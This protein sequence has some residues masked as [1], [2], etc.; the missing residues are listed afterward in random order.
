[1]RELLEFKESGIYCSAGDFYIDPWKPV[2]RA[3]LTHAHADHASAGCIHYLAHHHSVPALR[4]RLGEVISAQGV[5]YSQALDLN[6]VKVSLHPAGHIP[7]SAQVRVEYKGQ[8]WVVSGDYKLSDDGLSIPFEPVK[9]HVFVTESTFGL[10]VYTWKRQQEVFNEINQWWSGNREQGKASVIMGYT[11]GK[12]QRILQHVDHSIGKVYTHGAVENMNAVLRSAGIPLLPSVKVFSEAPKDRFRT[13][14]I[15]APPWAKGSTWLSRF[16]PYSL[17][18]ASGWMRLR[19]A[20]RRQAV[21]RGFVLSDHADWDEL[22]TA[23]KNSGAEKVYVTH[24]YT[25]VFAR[26]LNENGIEAH[27]VKTEYEGELA[28]VDDTKQNGG[29]EE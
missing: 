4:Y 26:W 29:G 2:Q 14:L 19:G 9:C 18:I 1:M 10:P 7:G 13:A 8:V 11:L 17:S 23:V 22:N 5:D 3:I 15:I 27:E 16:E 24:G 21:D 20:R 28:E 6:G 25:S 12:A